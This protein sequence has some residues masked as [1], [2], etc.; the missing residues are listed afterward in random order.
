MGL[1]ALDLE[2]RSTNPRMNAHA[3]LEPWRVRQ[4][5][6]EIS[7]ISVCRPDNSVIRIVNNG[8]NWVSQ[9]EDLLRSLKGQVVYAHNAMFDIAWCIATTHPERCSVISNLIRDI[10]W[11]DT[12]L[13]VKWLINGQKAENIRFS[14]SLINLATTFLADHPLIEEFKKVKTQN[15]A[16]GEDAQYWEERGDIDTIMTKALADKLQPRL[17]EEQRV[18]F[19][20]ECACLI[21]VANSWINGIRVNVSNISK[22]SMG[23][24]GIMSKCTRDLGVSPEELK[25]PK[26]LGNL[27]FNEWG[28]TPLKYGKTGG[29]TAKDDLL[30]IQYAVRNSGN[31]TLADKIDLVMDF[32]KN[33][34]L[35]SK[36]IKTLLEALEHTGDGYIYGTP[37]LFGTYTGRMTYSNSTLDKYKTSI[38]LHQLPRKAKDVRDL[39]CAP[40]GMGL[41]ENDAS[42]QESRLMAIR[43][44][45][46]T[47]IKIFC[48]DMNFH[49]MT[50]SGIIGL[51]YAEFM[52]KYY[53]QAETGGYY[54]EQRQLGKL[55][56]LSCNYRIGGKALAQKAFTQY[57]TYMTEETGRF[58]VNTF[59]RQYP[60][61][62]EYWKSTVREARALGY[63]ECYGGRRYKISEW[64]S[65]SWISE[66]SA[67]NFPIQG[68]G[69]SMKEVA[70][71]VLF[72]KFPE[73]HFCLDL[74][75]ATFNFCD[76]DH[77]DELEKEVTDT[78]N[79]IDYEPYW[80]FKPICPLTYE[81][82]AGLTFK[83]VK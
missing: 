14:Y 68:A 56:N 25:S 28:L 20:T 62:P 66:S 22:V 31:D 2:T 67:I 50:G 71:A 3:A 64:G 26:R 34:T 17:P 51:D 76:I 29:S 12:M 41:I 39:L 48:D 27:L 77:R 59:Q 36:Y 37:R 47:M 32:K 42:G 81:S 75:D 35:Q 79:S 46:P 44:G 13:L 7:S 61:V 58:L 5:N 80:G 6:A 45:D 8:N 30:L 54:V 16:A 70:I 11:R 69:A 49:S 65:D 24:D 10:K 19:M 9:V 23:I 38:A 57:D 83:D 52:E 40:P 78:L 43:S 73:V 15:V 82:A 53:E 74:H 18:G 63:T 4:G 33:A 72:A 1:Y 55:T 60:G 21:P